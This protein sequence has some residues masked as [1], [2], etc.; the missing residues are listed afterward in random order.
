MTTHSSE[1][2]VSGKCASVMIRCDKLLESFRAGHIGIDEYAY[3]LTTTLVVGSTCIKEC[4]DRLPKIVATQLFP[5]IDQ[6]LRPADFMPCPKLFLPN[7]PSE[8]EIQETKVKLR[9]RY[10]QIYQLI[11]EK[12]ST[13]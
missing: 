8:E 6:F 10:I 5:Y 13:R 3:N 4:I 11:K 12:I 1:K 9:P 7:P 2:D